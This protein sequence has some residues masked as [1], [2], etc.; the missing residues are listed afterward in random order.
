MPALE[1]AG[2]THAVMSMVFFELEYMHSRH[3]SNHGIS[4]I[5]TCLHT[6][7]CIYL[8]VIRFLKGK[9]ICILDRKCLYNSQTGIMNSVV[10][11]PHVSYWEICNLCLT[12][13]IKG[14]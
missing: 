10:H 12:V 6:N 8:I 14:Q 13:I 5:I 7:A 3:H 11:K 1:C 4:F 2:T 9:K